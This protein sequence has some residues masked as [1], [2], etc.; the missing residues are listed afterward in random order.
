MRITKKIK[1]I[2]NWPEERKLKVLEEIRQ[3]VS[4]DKSLT[5]V[6]CSAFVCQLVE[7]ALQFDTVGENEAKM[8]LWN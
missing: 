4:R 7:A 5:R 2:R 1:T 3:I 6:K 8:I